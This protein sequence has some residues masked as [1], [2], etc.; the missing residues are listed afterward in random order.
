MRCRWTCTTPIDIHKTQYIVPYAMH[1]ITSIFLKRAL[2]FGGNGSFEGIF[3]ENTHVHCRLIA[4]NFF[5]FFWKFLH[6]VLADTR[7]CQ[8]NTETCMNQYFVLDLFAHQNV[9]RSEND[10]FFYLNNIQNKADF[11]YFNNIRKTTLLNLLFFS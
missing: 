6:F 10:D 8:A 3:G 2:S 5:L 1:Q 11:F 9:V 7:Y 4:L